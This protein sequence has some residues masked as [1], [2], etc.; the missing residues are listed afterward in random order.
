MSEL[1]ES[2]EDVDLQSAVQHVTVDGNPSCSLHR[3]RRV[4]VMAHRSSLGQWNYGQKLT[5]LPPANF[6]AQRLVKPFD[7]ESVPVFEPLLTMTTE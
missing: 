5:E 7:Q 4:A 2:N 3:A 1:V 6:W